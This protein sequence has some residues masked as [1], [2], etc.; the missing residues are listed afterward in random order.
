[1]PGSRV[2]VPP[3][4]LK[5]VL[6]PRSSQQSVRKRAS[7]S[8]TPC[9]D[10]DLQIRSSMSEHSWRSSPAAGSQKVASARPFDSGAATEQQSP[11][12]I[13][14]ETGELHRLLVESVKDYA[15][16]ALDPSGYILSWNIGAERL[17]GYKAQEI[18]GKHFS[19]FYPP[20]KVA[21]H[22]PDYELREAARVGRFEDEGWR[23]RKDGSRFWANVVITA[24]HNE[25]G[26]LV[27]YAKVTRDLSERR[28][29]EQRA[30]EDARRVA[31]EESARR[32]AEE[33]RT[34][35]DRLQSLTAA[36]SA[37]HTVPEIVQ[38]VLDQGLRDVGAVAGS[39]GLSDET[40]K[41]IRIV[42]SGGY[43][44]LPSW[45][46][47]LLVDDDLPMSQSV[48]EGRA[49]ICRTRAERDE[50]YPKL[51]SLLTPYESTAVFP[52]HARSG[53]MG[54]LAIHH[55]DAGE[56]TDETLSFM[57]GFAQQ[58]AQALERAELYEAEQ[59]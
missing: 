33:T 49:I 15:I 18:I 24:L 22:F 31:A 59:V 48:R 23:I 16:F 5:R 44:E 42:G 36:L 47:P 27:G 7:A 51:A 20:E 43:P 56:L 38:V 21:E 25:A 9:G 1:M 52:L 29:A 55:A 54:A 39:L 6:P 28:E 4:L 41:T 8:L 40:H 50:R 34:R 45:A 2:R 35:S 58:V 19:I 30:I 17:K 53:T 3:Q 37:A 10:R 13:A 46:P 14:H 57:D 12:G 32:V 11:G 26:A